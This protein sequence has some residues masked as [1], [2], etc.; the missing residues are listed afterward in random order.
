M[1]KSYDTLLPSNDETNS[2]GSHRTLQTTISAAPHLNAITGAV[3]DKKSQTKL[4]AASWRLGDA[5]DFLQLT[6][7]ELM[8]LQI[9]ESLSQA[10]RTMR[11]RQKSTQS[12]LAKRIHS[13]QARVARIEGA[14]AS[15]S[16]D[17]MLQALIAT[18][19]NR[20]E[21]NKALQL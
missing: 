18:G 6:E 11:M 20:K 7:Q 5:Q 16:A 12:E 9:K 3:I 15:V 8:L 17:L 14:D 1:G 10:V 4:R 2:K 21:I 19:A 13:S